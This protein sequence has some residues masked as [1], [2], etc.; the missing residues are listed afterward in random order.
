M[1]TSASSFA[2]SNDRPRES[3]ADIARKIAAD[4]RLL[5]SE[6]EERK[7]LER[8]LSVAASS[9]KCLPAGEVDRLRREFGCLHE[10]EQVA[11]AEHQRF[12]TRLQEAEVEQAL[13]NFTGSPT[14]IT[15][16]ATRLAKEAKQDVIRA[17]VA[18]ANEKREL[19]QIEEEVSCSRGRLAL[20]SS[21]RGVPR[22][23]PQDIVRATAEKLDAERRIT[24]E[25]QR[26]LAASLAG[27]CTAASRCAALKKWS[28][29]LTSELAECSTDLGQFGDCVR[30]ATSELAA[31]QKITEQEIY[32][33]KTRSYIALE[34]LE[35]NA[36]AE[37]KIVK[38]REEIAYVEQTSRADCDKL[39]EEIQ[40]QRDEIKQITVSLPRKIEVEVEVVKDDEKRNVKKELEIA[41]RKVAELQEDLSINCQELSTIRKASIDTQEL[42]AVLQAELEALRTA[43]ERVRYHMQSELSHEYSCCLKLCQSEEN[44]TADIDR[45]RNLVYQRRAQF[46][47]SEL[48]S[49]QVSSLAAD[50]ERVEEE[51]CEYEK[52]LSSLEEAEAQARSALSRCV[53][54]ATTEREEVAKLAMNLLKERRQEVSLTEALAEIERS[55][56]ATEAEVERAGTDHR[57]TE[58]LCDAVRDQLQLNERSA[59]DQASLASVLVS[60]MW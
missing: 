16:L 8:Q 50:V 52:Q 43:D 13:G 20:L 1:L 47:H 21:V 39:C 7:E 30:Q 54:A 41:N 2:L 44:L 3:E 51:R 26:S 32:E 45:S 14:S 36:R 48:A 5:W 23:P 11:L 10:E 19:F 46:L 38:L 59:S 25:L 56:A 18:E 33:A 37:M 15:A 4:R 34:S 58:E 12:F 42:N 17:E 9:P 60:K 22:A 24:A 49:R 55:R 31:G 40:S 57:R 28:E 27:K 29:D 6:V 53:A 35:A